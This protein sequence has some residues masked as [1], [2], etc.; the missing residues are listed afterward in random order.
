MQIF[1]TSTEDGSINRSLFVLDL[2]TNKRNKLSTQIGTNSA[3]F[4]N[5]LKYYVNTFSDAN[6]PPVY[7][8][9]KADGSLI[10]TLEDNSD[11]KSKL[12]FILNN[13]EVYESIVDQAYEDVK[14]H[15]YDHR[16]DQMLKLFY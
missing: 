1:F 12:E 5:G 15:S 8:L 13:S 9:H 3:K 14:W 10:K 4:S 16:I 6:T 11:F 2:E 7:T